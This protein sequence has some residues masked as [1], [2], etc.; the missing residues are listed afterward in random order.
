MNKTKQIWYR[1]K[2]EPTQ[3]KNDIVDLIGK[4]YLLLGQK[5]ETEQIVLMAKFLHQDLIERYSSMEMQEV[6]HAILE[7]LRF[8][9]TGGFV[10]LRNLNQ[11]LKE[12]KSRS[13]LKR[14]QHQLTDYEVSQQAQKQIESTIQKA[15]QI[16]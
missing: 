1:F 2:N 8:S 14:Q 6:E 3:L 7:G 12:H 10:N 15:K 13:A 11:W 16:K 4:C 9:E 5:P